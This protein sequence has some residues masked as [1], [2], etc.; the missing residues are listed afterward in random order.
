MI[1]V[2]N[3]L[4][5]VALD[6]IGVPGIRTIIVA[7]LVF[8]CTVFHRLFM[9]STESVVAPKPMKKPV[10]VAERNFV[11]CSIGAYFTTLVC[12][13][14]IFSPEKQVSTGAHQVFGP[15]DTTDFDLL[16]Y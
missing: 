11:I 3:C 1:V 8:G 15:C 16:G 6:K 7:I 13:M 2:L 12:I 14:A 5:L 9:G 10:R 4:M